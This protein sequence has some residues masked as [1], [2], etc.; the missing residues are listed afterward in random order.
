M[1]GYLGDYFFF[2]FDFLFFLFFEVWIETFSLKRGCCEGFQCF[3]S[4]TSQ[5][6]HFIFVWKKKML[7]TF[8]SN[9]NINYICNLQFTDKTILSIMK[10]YKYIYCL[11]SLNANTVSL[12]VFFWT[13]VQCQVTFTRMHLKKTKTKLLLS[14]SIHG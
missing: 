9:L 10:L 1:V 4:H 7:F 14:F 2:F 13:L 6:V 8:Q 12:H 5:I 11:K 3:S